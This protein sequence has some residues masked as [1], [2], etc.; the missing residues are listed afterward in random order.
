MKMSKRVMKRR[1]ALD[2]KALLGEDGGREVG[3]ASWDEKRGE[4]EGRGEVASQGG[5][6]ETRVGER[7]VGETRGGDTREGEGEEDDEWMSWSQ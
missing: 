4:T 5:V 7:R 2:R 3:E 1:R 6:G